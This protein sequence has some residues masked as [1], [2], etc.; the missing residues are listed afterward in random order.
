MPKV[1]ASAELLFGMLQSGSNDEVCVDDCVP[2]DAVLTE[3]ALSRSRQ[4]VIFYFQTSGDP[5]PHREY[6]PVYALRVQDCD[7]ICGDDCDCAPEAAVD[8][9]LAPPAPPTIEEIEAALDA[10]ATAMAA[11]SEPPDDDAEDTSSS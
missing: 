11:S 5:E 6:S 7:G 10:A 9:T 8:V 1:I 3:V 2:D 4:T